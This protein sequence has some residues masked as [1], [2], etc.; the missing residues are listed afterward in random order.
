MSELMK[1]VA[2]AVKEG[3]VIGEY[4]CQYCGQAYRKE[5]SLAA[6][7]CE[8]KR[9]AQQKTEVGVQLGYQAWIRF[10]ELSQ[11]SAKTKTYEDF[12]KNQFYTAFVKFGRHCHAIGAINAARF[13]DYVIKNN[14]RIDH[15]THEKHY[16]AYLQEIIRTEAVRDALERGINTMVSWGEEL[17]KPFNEYFREVSSPRLVFHIQAGRISP[18][19][20]YTCDSGIEALSRLNE[21]EISI[22]WPFIDSDLWQRKMRDYPGD[23]EIA[24]HVLKEAGI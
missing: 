24:R 12:A 22:V 4:K 8:P 18:W 20:M 17:D 14:I 16:S 21:Q 23:T 9:R 10:Y 1:I 3:A 19:L 2:E 11:G 6:H 13:I 7:Q 5:T 15:W